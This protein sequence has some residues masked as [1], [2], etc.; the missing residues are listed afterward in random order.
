MTS[1]ICSVICYLIIYKTLPL[2]ITFMPVHNALVSNV[3]RIIFDE[4]ITFFYSVFIGALPKHNKMS[5]NMHIFLFSFVSSVDFFFVSFQTYVCLCSDAWNQD[6]NPLFLLWQSKDWSSFLL[7]VEVE[8][9][10]D[11]NICSFTC[12]SLFSMCKY[13]CN[14]SNIKV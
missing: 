9:W 13:Q 10:K 2:F 3:L 11:E 6:A 12:I 7:V 5:L 8:L 1:Q 4:T 14:N